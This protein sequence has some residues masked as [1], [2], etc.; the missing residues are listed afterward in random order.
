MATIIKRN[1]ILHNEEDVFSQNA[2]D[3]VEWTEEMKQE[4]E[5]RIKQQR[6]E[7]QNNSDDIEK[8]EPQ[9]IQ[10][11]DA[12]YKNHGD[13]FFKDRKWLFSEFPELRANL[14]TDSKPTK[15]LEVGC[16]VGNAVA[17]IFNTNQNDNLHVYCCDLSQNAINTLREREFYIS[18][19]DKIISFQA[20]ICTDFE[21][22][23]CQHVEEGS[24][25]FITVI[26]TLSAL[27]PELMGQ[28]I[29]NLTKLL[30]DDGGMLL[31][32]DYAKY[33]LTQ[34]RFK[35][36]AYLRE[37]YYVRSD[38]T[39]SYFFNR[40]IVDKLMVEAGLTQVSL[41]EDNRML[42]NRLKSLK[43]CRRWIQAKYVKKLV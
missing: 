12:F 8:I 10:K 31:F 24:L 1:R 42:I 2:W 38:G 4:A 43:M 40:E 7:S 11:W 18:N 20:D 28:T 27:K 30:R 14:E 21:T 17:H 32:R 13:K 3:D 29:K 39:T 9:I 34:L 16:G 41:T 37:D 6:E 22:K 35:P 33:D 15:I 25:D 19:Q 5:S 23:I 26:F 36:T